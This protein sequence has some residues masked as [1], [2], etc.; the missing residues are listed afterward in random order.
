MSCNNK[1]QKDKSPEDIG[2]GS[3]TTTY[4]HCTYANPPSKKMEEEETKTIYI[5][6]FDKQGNTYG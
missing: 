1:M 2:Y 5:D 4:H 6:P 3:M